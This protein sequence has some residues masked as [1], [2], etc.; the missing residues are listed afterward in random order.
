MPGRPRHNQAMPFLFGRLYRRLGTRYF[1]IYVVFECISAFVVCLATVGI[2]ALY[3]E[4]SP[5]EFWR[6]VAVAE[7]A[8]LAAVAWAMARAWQLTR[9]IIRW[10]GA[11][12][13]KEGALEVW[14]DA[15]SLPR[16]MAVALRRH[17]RRDRNNL[18]PGGGRIGRWRWPAGV[19]RDRRR[20]QFGGPCTGSY[21][22]NRGRGALTEAT[23]RAMNVRNSGVYA[24]GEAELR[25]IAD[26]VRL[27]STATALDER[28]TLWRKSLITDA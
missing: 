27:Y 3:T 16:A 10:V 8:T 15:V 28:S 5:A 24:Q 13:L 9:P 7:G 22:R 19:L 26:P 2:F 17:G 11:G 6:V 4:T 20:G 25:G 14:R 21:A 23:A 18:R 12:G 1:A